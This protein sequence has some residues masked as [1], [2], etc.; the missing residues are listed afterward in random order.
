[1]KR[2]FTIS[3]ALFIGFVVQSQSERITIPESLKKLPLRHVSNTTINAPVNNNNA[4]NNLKSTYFDEWTEETI[5]ES[6]FDLQTNYSSQNRI[7]L[8]SDGTVG[9]TWIM[10][11]GETTFPDRG[12][13]YNYYDGTEWGPIPTER[14]ESQKC[15]W[16][17]YAAYAAGGE[18]II[19]HSVGDDGLVINKRETKGSGNWNEFFF[20]GPAGHED[21]VW[22]R[23][24][25]NGPNYLNF[26]LFALTLPVDNGGSIYNGMDGALLYSRSLDGGNTWDIEHLQLDGMTSAEY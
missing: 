6:R 21:M 19:S 1:M 8:H 24:V 11:F 4:V 9:G 3:L 17:S 10:G 2:Y 7:Y 16:P 26:H 22:P 20:P 18:V 12:T 23:M 5:G 13:G 25:T 14:I 15:G